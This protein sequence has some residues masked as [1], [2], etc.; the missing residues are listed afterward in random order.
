MSAIARAAGIIAAGQNIEV[1]AQTAGLT[2]ARKPEESSTESDDPFQVSPSG[3]GWS[4][5]PGTVRLQTSQ[6]KTVAGI[7][8]GTSKGTPVFIIVRIP[9]SS[10]GL[11]TT[12]RFFTPFDWSTEIEL[13]DDP[14]LEVVTP[15][16]LIGYSYVNA[17]SPSDG[18]VVIPMAFW[19]GSSMHQYWQGANGI[20]VLFYH[21]HYTFDSF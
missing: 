17:V 16:A 7:H 11:V 9:L 13:R 12:H 15:S 5:S 1:N 19:D 4:V 18:D 21:G 2:L 8:F 6:T 14:L 3:S 20:D 10:L